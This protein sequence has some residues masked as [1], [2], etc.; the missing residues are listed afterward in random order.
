MYHVPYGETRLSSKPR[1]KVTCSSASPPSP[2]AL[3]SNSLGLAPLP[4]QT[5][6]DLKAGTES[7]GLWSLIRGLP[8]RRCLVNIRWI[9]FC[10]SRSKING[11]AAGNC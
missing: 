10:P 8:H 9:K 6:Q 2:P 11:I 1:T 5:G 4:F 3:H 7:G